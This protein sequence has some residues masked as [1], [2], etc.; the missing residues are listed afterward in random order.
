MQMKV[1]TSLF[2]AR[3]LGEDGEIGVSA[4]FVY[5]VTVMMCLRV[6][7]YRT[8][9]RLCYT[10]LKQLITFIIWIVLFMDKS[11]TSLYIEF[12]DSLIHVC[13][14]YVGENLLP[15]GDNDTSPLEPATFTTG[16]NT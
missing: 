16:I 10:S 1:N 8:T 2:C 11:V 7:W 5:I 6:L 4:F 15:S 14:L 12:T 13:V 3:P 9:H